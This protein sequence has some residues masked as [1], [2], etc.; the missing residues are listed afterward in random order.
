MG[1]TWSSSR[2]GGVDGGRREPVA[3]C[4]QG[5]VVGSG[6]SS[7][8]V[9]ARERPVAGVFAAV[10]SQLVRPRKLPSASRPLT[11]VRLLAYMRATHHRSQR[12]R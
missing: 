6:E 9:A 1:D 10:S 3:L 2:S 4:V 11:R 5:E 7:S 8:A 12:E